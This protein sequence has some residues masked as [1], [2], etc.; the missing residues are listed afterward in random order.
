MR[1][2]LYS[3]IV[4]VILLIIVIANMNKNNK[5]TFAEIKEVTVI[6]NNQQIIMDSDEEDELI[7]IFNK[8]SISSDRGIAC[9]T[10]DDLNIILSDGKNEITIVYPY[11]GC[12]NFLVKGKEYEYVF[13]NSDNNVRNRLDKIIKN[14]GV[15]IR[16]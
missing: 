8:A 12:N 4:L 6:E 1:K 9:G 10:I 5:F 16:N 11:D 14:K 2:K 3:S 15:D 13:I 7:Q